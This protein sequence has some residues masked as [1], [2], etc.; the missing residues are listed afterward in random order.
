MIK[1]TFER[2]TYSHLKADIEQKRKRNRFHQSERLAR[3]T[4]SS[5]NHRRPSPAACADRT[6]RTRI[7]PPSPIV[8][9][10]HPG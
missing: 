10:V 5:M 1:I 8:V 6:D 2:V 7:V 3:T 4:D 9:A